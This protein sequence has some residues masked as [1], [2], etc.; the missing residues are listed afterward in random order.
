MAVERRRLPGVDYPV[1]YRPDGSVDWPAADPTSPFWIEG[2][3][4][5]SFSGGRT[6]AL[7]LFLTLWAHGGE[8]P[9]D[10]YV[11]FA[12]TGKEREATLRFVH[13][14]ATEWGVEVRW[15]EFW[16][17]LASVGPEGRFVEVGFNSA[18]RAGEPFDRLIARKQAIPSTITGRWC[19]EFL[20]VTVL[21]DFATTL[22]LEAGRYFEVIGLRSDEGDRQKRLVNGRRS[23]KR[24]LRFPLIPAGVRKADVLAFWKAHRF[25][26]MLPRGTG[27]CD[28]CPFVSIK[29]RIARARLDAGGTTWW[30]RHEIERGRRFGHTYSFVELLGLVV[31]S[32]TFDADDDADTECGAF[33]GMGG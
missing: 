33:C 4:I 13:D 2:P 23:A 5:L 17:D 19:T 16:T 15:L 7:M 22:G 24:S 31:Q 29:N 30:A 11:A 9:A 10:V 6:S 21:H 18:S 32:P 25:D 26:L 12:N 28:H 8:L 1:P 27:N 3:A 14:C 20:K